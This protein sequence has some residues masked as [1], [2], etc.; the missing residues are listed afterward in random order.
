MRNE[1]TLKFR[2]TLFTYPLILI[3]IILPS[4]YYRSSNSLIDESYNSYLNRPIV[5]EYTSSLIIDL[6]ITCTVIL[7]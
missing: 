4:N 2:R 3:E 6:L 1:I 5:G 7:E